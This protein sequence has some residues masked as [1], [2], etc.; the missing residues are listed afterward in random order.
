MV[1]SG[2]PEESISRGDVGNTHEGPRRG[3][4]PNLLGVAFCE[5]P[6]TWRPPTN[7]TRRDS[8]LVCLWT[9]SWDGHRHREP[10]LWSAATVVH[11]Q[12]TPYEC[13]HHRRRSFAFGRWYL[14]WRSCTAETRK[15][16]WPQPTVPSCCLQAVCHVAAWCFRLWESSSRSLLLC[17]GY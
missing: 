3:L 9:L 2:S 8:R 5:Q 7:T 1:I 10:L 4:W 6:D 17:L 12:A 16:Q 13:V 11:I 14:E 15:P